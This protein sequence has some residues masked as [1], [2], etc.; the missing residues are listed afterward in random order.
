MANVVRVVPVYALKFGFNDKFR[1]M[2]REPGQTTRTLTTSQLMVA[3][4]MGGLCQI[5]LTY[6]LEVSNTSLRLLLAQ[7]LPELGHG[8]PAEC[9]THDSFPP[10]S[11]R[12]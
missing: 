10:A 9:N 12:L 8:R 6:P 7:T 5:I 2:V 4:T 3:G 1:Q 11:F